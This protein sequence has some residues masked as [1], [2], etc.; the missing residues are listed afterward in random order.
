MAIK[1]KYVE[2]E[3]GEIFVDNK[4]TNQLE[5]NISF[6]PWRLKE[7]KKKDK[8]SQDVLLAFFERSAF[9]KKCEQ[10]LMREKR[11]YELTPPIESLDEP[12]NSY[13]NR[14]F[15]F[16][17]TKLPKKNLSINSMN[18]DNIDQVYSDITK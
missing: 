15:V 13:S 18:V 3:C 7:A 16:K 1:R 9:C 11:Q 5:G 6:D 4:D 8:T 17:V 2:C 14:E 10:E 12:V